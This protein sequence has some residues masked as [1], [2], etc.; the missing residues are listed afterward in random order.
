M[1]K[2]LLT[3]LYSKILFK[4]NKILKFVDGGNKLISIYSPFFIYSNSEFIIEKTS[5][6]E[7]SRVHQHG[8]VNPVKLKDVVVSLN[9]G[10]VY[11]QY[12]DSY[13]YWTESNYRHRY[14]ALWSERR[15]IS[16]PN[17][18]I[19]EPIVLIPRR[20]GN[21]YHFFIEEL[22]DIL[23]EIKKLPKD[24]KII[25]SLGLPKYAKQFLQ[26][27]WEI[28]YLD[29]DFVHSNLLI[30]APKLWNPTNPIFTKR[31]ENLKKLICTLQNRKSNHP[32]KIFILRD[33]NN[34][35][36]QSIA[37]FYKKKGFFVS[38]LINLSIFDQIELFRDA[39]EIVGLAGAGFT[40]CVFIQDS[41]KSKLIELFI[42]QIKKVWERASG[43]ACWEPFASQMGMK[44]E[45]RIHN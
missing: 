24:G 41:Q 10:N 4:L 12:N 30:K 25:A 17:I 20:S 13:Y 2:N 8:T 42:P 6:N 9:S 38:T 3:K 23:N 26:H 32:K 1:P 21:Y 16:K 5:S 29:K 36:E 28:N 18:R 7:I 19:V 43:G 34:A 37:K 14:Q 44:Y 22:P 11:K 45:F 15:P 35:V 39:R 27:F 33:A 40:N 31:F